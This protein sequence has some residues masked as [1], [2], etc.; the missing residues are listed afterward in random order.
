MA[1][2]QDAT[3]YSGFSYQNVLNALQ[4]TPTMSAAGLAVVAA[5]SMKRA[6]TA[7]PWRLRR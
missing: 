1:G 6:T 3:G 7:G 2:S 4:A 5:R